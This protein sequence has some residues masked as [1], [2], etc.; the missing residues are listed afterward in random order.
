M[1]T[2][3][4]RSGKGSPLT[5]NEVDNNFTN[6]NTDKAEL[7]GA[8]FTGEIVANGG[9]ALGDNDK[10]TFGAGD[11]LQIYHDGTDS[12]V[13]DAGTGSLRLRGSS[14]IRLETASGTQM[15][16]ADDGGA[17]KLYH[18]GIKK[19]DTTSTGIN[20]TGN[21]NLPDSGKLLLGA[22]D[23]LQIYH[24]GTHS[25][26]SDQG[27]GS[28]FL[29]SGS[30]IYVQ[31]SGGT[32]NYFKGT[33]GGAAELFHNGSPKLA[34]TSTG[35]D[36]T[37]I[38]DA[39]DLIRFGV[40]NS[41]IANNY[42][43]FKSTG[44]AYI[45]H[46]T[47]GQVINFR[48]S[49]SSSLDTNALTIDSTGI[50][51]TGTA[52]MDGL[53][54]DGDAELVGNSINL[55]L[56]ESDQLDKNL[57]FR[58]NGG[59][60]S[61]QTLSDDKT[62]AANRIQIS[63]STGDVRF[64]EN[65][66]TTAKMVW[67][68]SAESLGIG[69]SPS[70]QL[71]VSKWI[72]TGSGA[73]NNGGL[74]FP[75]LNGSTS[76]RSY[77]FTNDKN[78]YGD[79]ALIVSDTA[80]SDPKVGST[81]LTVK[82]K[83]VGIGTNSPSD[84]LD[85]SANGT[86]AMRL[87][88]SSSPATYARITQA[89]GVLTFAADAGNTQAGSNMQ[90]EV[91]GA[92]AMRI[93]SSGNVGIGTGV[94]GAVSPILR[95]GNAGTSGGVVTGTLSLG[96]YSTAFGSN[97]V[98][99]SNF[100]SNSSS[101]LAFGTTPSGAAGGSQ[102][103]ERMR[104]DSSGNLLVGKSGSSLSTAGFELYSSG[105]QWMTSANARPLLLNRTGSDGAIQ[106]FRK[107]GTTVGSIGVKDGYLTAGN[108]DAGLLFLGSGVKRI[109]PWSVSSNSG[110]DNQI[111]LG[112][113]TERFKD[114]YL[115]GGVYLGGNVAAN[116]LD[117]YEEGTWTPVYAPSS[118]AFASITMDASSST[119]TKIGNLVYIKSIIRTDA[120]EVGTGAGNLK[121]TGLPFAASAGFGASASIGYAT[122]WLG[123]IPSAGYPQSGATYINL[124]YRTSANGG[125][126][127][128]TVA[129]LI[130]GTNENHNY[131]MISLTYQV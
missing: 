87:S 65:T 48:V 29:R 20:V 12:F 117:D 126:I 100:T 3:T 127:N 71:E 92:E 109:Q 32:A 52:T 73:F 22:G 76:S 120:F 42:V 112:Y 119:Y 68:A 98:S 114:L 62:T 36:V 74:I 2:I 43:R 116:K 101:Y 129:D 123:D 79:F 15:I 81:V 60:L 90:F 55:D 113:S 86:S 111:D 47:V 78:T 54:V 4:T 124:M 5:N 105:V 89:N 44:A 82:D 49:G 7:S 94:S 85:I 16:S 13:S 104:I 31:N 91:D 28:L 27:T 61:V 50:D 23:D 18:N 6:L 30:N 57:R 19:L 96:S 108:A 51:V 110:A 121:I 1:S 8:T 10:A 45:D 26:V 25:Y 46:S 69:G 63:H 106:E 131:I 103:T 37:G 66:G 125:L 95:L 53:T 97:I 122:N 88:D 34:T 38:V 70:E 102:P 80:S 33:D 75:Y 67:D 99:S 115:S 17:A 40:N 41:E 11:D 24:D 128:T 58:A 9:I 56:M 83:K 35:I 84:L 107:D 130:T 14:Q 93:D 39:S 72:K 21:V 118:G 64:Y 77:A 59:V